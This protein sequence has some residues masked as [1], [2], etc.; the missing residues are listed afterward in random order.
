VSIA[1]ISQIL[2]P[3]IGLASDRC[4][5]F[6]GRR[7]PFLIAGAALGVVGLTLQWIS[8]T[9]AWWILYFWSFALSMV[10]LNIISCGMFGLV[11]DRVP[12]EQSGQANGVMATLNV[13]GSIFGMI[14][15][16]I[17][18]SLASMYALYIIAVAVSVCITVAV[19]KEE[20][21]SAQ[22]PIT[23]KEIKTAFW[24]SPTEHHDFFYV[25]LSRTLYYMGVSSQTFFMYFLRDV[26][27]VPDPEAATS[28]VA[29][30][31]QLFG[32]VTALP[33][34]WA[35]DSMGIGRKPFVYAACAVMSL[36]NVSFLF[37]R[38]M[39]SVYIVSAAFGYLAGLH[40]VLT[41]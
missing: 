21:Q 11:P 32:A 39:G 31:G 26:V 28:R 22:P 13:C 24:L 40:T 18:K 14:Y 17:T 35:S 41:Y 33:A 16:Q 27:M 2:N 34:G 36:G 4:S 9:Y 30:V 1:G 5:H 12:A 20:R 19:V 3:I 23:R 38:S 29:I 7:R 8:S 15:F 6:L 10:A 25:T 37:L